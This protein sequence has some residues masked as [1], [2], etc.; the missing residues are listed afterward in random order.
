[1]QT[2]FRR[3][4]KQHGP[5]VAVASTDLFA[6]LDG[7]GGAAVSGSSGGSSNTVATTS[8]VG[9][10]TNAGDTWTNKDTNEQWFWTGSAW[11]QIIGL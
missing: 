4:W 11:Q 2:V 5:T 6:L 1:M 8:P 7:T 3:V 9:S 10:G